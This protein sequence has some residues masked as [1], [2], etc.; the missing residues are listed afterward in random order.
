LDVRIRD[1]VLECGSPLCRC[2]TAIGQKFPSAHSYVIDNQQP[3]FW[4]FLFPSPKA[5]DLL[6]F[7]LGTLARFM[8]RL[9]LTYF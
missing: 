3:K 6:R 1:S 8:V 7:I 9:L 4:R 5:T 2:G